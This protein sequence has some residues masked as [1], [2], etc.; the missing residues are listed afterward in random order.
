MF[1]IFI[2]CVFVFYKYNFLSLALYSLQLLVFF[3]LKHV[4]SFFKVFKIVS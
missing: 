1:A 4:F 2:F 3:Y